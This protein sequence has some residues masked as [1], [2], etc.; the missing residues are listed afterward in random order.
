MGGQYFDPLPVECPFCKTKAAYPLSEL[1]NYLAQCIHCKKSLVQVSRKMDQSRYANREEL[2][3]AWIKFELLGDALLDESLT[4]ETFDKASTLGEISEICGVPLGSLAQHPEISSYIKYFSNQ[5]MESIRIEDIDALQSPLKKTPFNEFALIGARIF[6]GEVFL[7]NHAVVVKEG[8]IEQILPVDQLTSDIQLIELN[9]GILAPGFIDLQVNG[10]GGDFFTDKP[11]LSAIKNILNAHRC[12]GTTALLPTLVSEELATYQKAMHAILLAHSTGFKGV[13]GLH[14]EGPFFA[15][16]K[17]GAHVEKYIRNINSTDI[18]WLQN[19]AGH[20]DLKI[21][22]TLAPETIPN[23][24]I[25]K[26]SQQGILVFAGHTD[27][28][29][30]QIQSAITEGLYGFTHLY[31][32]MRPTTARDPGVVAAALESHNSWCG[33]ILDGHHVHPAN[34]RIACQL[35]KDKLFLI[36][37][38][39]A[40][41]GSQS[42][43][44]SLYGEEITETSETPPKLINQQGKLAGSAI[45]LIDAVRYATVDVGV[46]LAESLRM[47]SLYPARCLQLDHYLGKIQP[48]YRADLVHFTEDFDV[49]AT[50]VAGDWLLHS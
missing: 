22:L 46:E 17:R 32:A 41:L 13:L 34:A 21:L 25:Q 47:A 24:I 14:I 1:D 48:G 33:I 19:I 11:Y 27:A 29:Y 42:K 3:I 37:D 18:E 2:G 5:P 50:W 15:S 7:D 36:S 44:F 43:C 9:K 26:L 45:G 10:G 31:N 28:S 40:T 12:K 20:S 38:S 6:T 35:K 49:T 8:Y 23:G 4:D 16:G 39:M 30:E